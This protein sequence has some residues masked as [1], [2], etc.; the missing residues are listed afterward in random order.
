M[1]RIVACWIFDWLF[2]LPNAYDS[3][4][5]NKSTYPKTIAWRDRYNT[6]VAAAKES[7]PTPTELDGEATVSLILS[8]PLTD[9]DVKFNPDPT[10]LKEGA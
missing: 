3:N 4:F 7:A 8:S 10:G 1:T 6:A 2:Q 5:I 9:Q